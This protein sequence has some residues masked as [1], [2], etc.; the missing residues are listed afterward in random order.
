MKRF[1]IYC[2][3][4]LLVLSCSLAGATDIVVTFGGDCTLGS[5]ERFWDRPN[6][7]IQMVQTYGK[8]YPFSW[9]Y[10]IF[11]QD[12]LTVVN[13]EGTFYDSTLGKVKKKYNFRAPLDYAEILVKGSVEAVGLG[14]NHSEDYGIRGFESTTEALEAVS[15]PWFVDCQSANKAYVYEKEGA[16]IGFISFNS[17]YY[18]REKGKIAQTFES[19]RSL[20]VDA[21][22]GIMHGGS[23]YYLRHNKLQTEMADFCIAQG[24][25]VV[26]GHHPHVL[27]GVEVRENESIFYSIGNLVFGGNG[28]IRGDADVATLVQVRFSFDE[29]GIYVGHQ[30]TLIPIHPSS[31]ED[32]KINNFMPIPATGAGAQRALQIIGED[33]NIILG[34]FV[35]GVGVTLPFVNAPPPPPDPMEVLIIIEQM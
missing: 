18:Y 27:Q 12:D 14:N 32:P 30:A 19:V 34:E 17:T 21:I 26:I 10:P 6:H 29:N 35:E 16:R 15:I 5:E 24:A 13:L 1:L 31:S 25:T 7:F 23:E 22:V 4:L 8:A 3:L 20:G 33:S 28:T 2:L 9:L 11:S